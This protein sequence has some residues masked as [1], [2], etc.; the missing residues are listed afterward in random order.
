[1]SSEKRQSIHCRYCRSRAGKWQP[2]EHN[3]SHWPHILTVRTE[4][5]FCC[6]CR[7][8]SFGDDV[9]RFF[10]KMAN[11][12]RAGDI[13]GFTSLGGDYFYTNYQPATKHE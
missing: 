13:D 5:W 4:G 10:E 3:I 2:V 11:K 1:M 7:Q 12:L 9:L 8:T 6:S